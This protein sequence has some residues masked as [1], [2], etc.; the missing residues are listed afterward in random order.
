MLC[1]VFPVPATSERW[2]E[3][4]WEEEEDGGGTNTMGGD[5][6]VGGLG[7]LGREGEKELSLPWEE[8]GGGG[9]AKGRGGKDAREKKSGSRGSGKSGMSGGNGF[10]KESNFYDHEKNMR[11]KA[12]VGLN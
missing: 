1:R 9:V 5:E 3:E 7:A 6:R 11:V 8:K 2:R 12:R 4:P 10:D